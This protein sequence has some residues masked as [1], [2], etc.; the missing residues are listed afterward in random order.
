M[1]GMARSGS[2]FVTAGWRVTALGEGNATWKIP[3]G[4]RRQPKWVPSEKG[5]VPFFSAVHSVRVPVLLWTAELTPLSLPDDPC[6][7]TLAVQ[8]IHCRFP[9][10]GKGLHVPPV[11]TRGNPLPVLQCTPCL[12]STYPLLPGWLAPSTLITSLAR[13]AQFAREE[14]H[15]NTA[16]VP[17]EP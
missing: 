7:G 12:P 2:S 11:A 8:L 14:G 17:P 16:P 10:T 9:S 13:I 6:T 5:R 15:S 4:D 3:P 1:A